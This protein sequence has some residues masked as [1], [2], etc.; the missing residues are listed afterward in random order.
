MNFPTH[1]QLEDAYGRRLGARVLLL[2]P[3]M[4]DGFERRRQPTSGF[5]P[6]RHLGY[7]VQWFALAAT[8]V[9]IYVGV[10]LQPGAVSDP[11]R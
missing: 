8:L 1:A 5:G 7:A 11:I 9:A 4:P 2:D 6:E 3:D 10:N